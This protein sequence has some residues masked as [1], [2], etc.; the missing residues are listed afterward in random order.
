MTA[1]PDESV[2]VTPIGSMSISTQSIIEGGVCLRCSR[3]KI[4]ELVIEEPSVS[5]VVKYEV[6][7]WKYSNQSNM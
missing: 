7:C 3:C 2:V 6:I 5:V 1:L 4:T